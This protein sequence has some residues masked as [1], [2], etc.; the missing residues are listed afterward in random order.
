MTPTVRRA[1]RMP[2]GSPQVPVAIVGAGACGLTAALTLRDAGIDCVLLERDAR[3]RGSTAL[4]SGFIPAAG[5][6]V[7]RAA[8]VLDDS[9]ARFAHDIRA[10][11]HGRAGA[12]KVGPETQTKGTGRTPGGGGGWTRGLTTR[13]GPLWPGLRFFRVMRGCAAAARGATR[14]EAKP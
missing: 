12:A 4:S 14:N 5:T 9:P 11:A 13:L 6:A 2:D 3:S 8:G 1:Q 10:K 7:Q